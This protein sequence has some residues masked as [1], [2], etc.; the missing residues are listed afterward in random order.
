LTGNGGAGFA[1]TVY[2][3]AAKLQMNGNGCASTFDALIVVDT[4]EMNGNPACL[5]SAYARSHNVDLP[6]DE[7]HLTK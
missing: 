5:R 4:V 2:A 3:R 1:G 7:L 6:A